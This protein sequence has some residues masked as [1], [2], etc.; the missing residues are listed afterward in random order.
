[1]IKNYVNELFNIKDKVAVITGAGGYLCGE[2]AM[3]LYKAGASI[4][5][6]L[7]KVKKF[8]TEIEQLRLEFDF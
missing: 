4:K 2:I 3:A 7:E 8:N 1:M 5:D 6:V